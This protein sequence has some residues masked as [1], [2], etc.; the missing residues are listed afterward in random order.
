[1]GF[2]QG[3]QVPDPAV[4]EW[5]YALDNFMGWWDSIVAH[6]QATG[7]GILTFTTEFGPAPY[8]PL[9]PFTKTPV[10]D[11]FSVNCYTKDLLNTRY[12]S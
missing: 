1:V 10:A 2:E 9:I 5:A 3:P 8:M 11:Q 4:P 6:N 7:R 12:R